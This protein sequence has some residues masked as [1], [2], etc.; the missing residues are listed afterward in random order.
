MV[1]GASGLVGRHLTERLLREGFKVCAVYYAGTPRRAHENLQWVRCDLQQEPPETVDPASIDTLVHAAALQPTD[2]DSDEVCYRVNSRIDQQVFAYCA[3]NPAMRIAYLSSIYIEK[4]PETGLAEHS[5]Y[6]SG[7]LDS[8][9]QLERMKNPWAVFRISSPYGIYQRYR[10]VL[11][12]F[13]ENAMAGKELL[14][15]GSGGRTQDFIAADDIADAILIYIQKNILPGIFNI[16]SSSPVSMKE[17]ADIIA[18]R[19]PRSVAVRFAGQPDPQEQYRS[20]FDNSSARKTLGW[21]P[22]T[23]LEEGI[24]DWFNYLQR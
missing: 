6:L 8:E 7:K 20:D 10:N 23:S 24:T 2:T 13:M 3:R 12:K 18:V 14:V 1:T 21:A 16:C 5:L 22:R 17:L 19:A 4:Y 9:R 15:Y 11:K